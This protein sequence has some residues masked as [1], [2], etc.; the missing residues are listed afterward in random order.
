M[1]DSAEILLIPGN[2]NHT[3][4]SLNTRAFMTFEHFHL[5]FDTPNTI[6]EDLG[7]QSMNAISFEL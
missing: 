5:I 4:L 3:E 2:G 6:L 7:D 1:M